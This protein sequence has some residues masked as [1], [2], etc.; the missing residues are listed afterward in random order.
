MLASAIKTG[1]YLG[2]VIIAVLFAAVSAYYYFKVIQAM[3][4]KEGDVIT[5][6]P[7]TNRFKYL[8]VA[9]AVLVVILGVFP[10]LLLQNLYF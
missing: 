7:V 6:A 1:H 3:Y 4:F 5:F 10:N 2:L 8:M 9:V